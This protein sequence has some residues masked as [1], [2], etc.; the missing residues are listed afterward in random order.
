M[1]VVLEP[2]AS[3]LC[4]QACERFATA[5]GELRLIDTV[6]E[7]GDGASTFPTARQL[8]AVYG[9]FTDEDL[10]TLLSGFVDQAMAMVAL[11]KAAGGLIE[12]Q[13]EALAGALSKAAAEPAGL[14]SVGLIH[15]SGPDGFILDDQCVMGGY[16]RVGLEDVSASPLE[17]IAQCSEA[18]QPQQYLDIQTKATSVADGLDDAATTLQGE[19]S[20]VLGHGWQGEF[21]E[22]AQYSV[23]GL[24]QS[25][26]SLS[27]A[28]RQVAD[29]AASA[30]HGFE[31]T[32][33]TIAEYAAQGQAAT[34]RAS[35][36]GLVQGPADGGAAA[37]SARAAAQ[38]QA[39]E[40][41]A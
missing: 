2:E 28:L 1:T 33:T 35:M 9:L 22:N 27:G 40:E 34:T 38:R 36:A 23:R 5:I 16:G 21:A 11:F 41:Q 26:H 15:G 20:A 25:A 19:L 10:K 24:V 37:A 12:A 32:R 6:F 4:S 13:D 31:A 18:L 39:A 3:A 30:H 17:Y 14:Q 8:G 29:K 7:Q